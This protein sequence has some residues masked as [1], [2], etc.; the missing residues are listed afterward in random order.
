[1]E[2]LKRLHHP[3]AHPLREMVVYHRRNSGWLWLWR[4]VTPYLRILLGK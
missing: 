2:R 1:M 4:C 3:K